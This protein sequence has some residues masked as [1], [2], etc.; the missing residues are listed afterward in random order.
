MLVSAVSAKSPV[1]TLPPCGGLQPVEMAPDLKAQGRAWP[2]P[3]APA[4]SDRSRTSSGQGDQDV[5]QGHAL[6]D[7]DTSSCFSKIGSIR[8]ELQSAQRCFRRAAKAASRP[9]HHH[10]VSGVESSAIG[11]P[12]PGCASCAAH[13]QA[14]G[15]IAA[16]R[17]PSSADQ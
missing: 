4:A 1:R 7:S 16:C 2:G 14:G 11:C 13:S 15:S 3:D 10:L 8:A 9:A 12:V 6:T 5:V 17:R